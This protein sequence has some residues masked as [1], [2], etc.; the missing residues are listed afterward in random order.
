M[1]I[2]TI[3]ITATITAV[4]FAIVGAAYLVSR[5]SDK[6]ATLLKAIETAEIKAEQAALLAVEAESKAVEARPRLEVARAKVKLFTSSKLQVAENADAMQGG[7]LAHSCN[8][9]LVTSKI[10]IDALFDSLPEARAE[11]RN[12]IE[13]V[14]AL[15]EQL[16]LEIHRGDAWKAAYELESELTEAL[17]AEVKYAKR[18]TKVAGAVGGALLLLLV[19]L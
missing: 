15:D 18:A 12:L 6:P 17:K 13:L 7:E 5:V 9:E 16:T 19:L 1:K 3:A 14:N 2:K 8:L 11:I 10:N 4:S